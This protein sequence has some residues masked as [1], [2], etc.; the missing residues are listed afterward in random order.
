[1]GSTNLWFSDGLNVLVHDYLRT[2]AFAIVAETIPSYETSEADCY[3]TVLYEKLFLSHDS[4]AAILFSL[5]L[6]LKYLSQQLL[7]GS[8]LLKRQ[9]NWR[10]MKVAILSSHG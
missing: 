2:L 1:M 7:N 4:K 6:F 3:F 9:K 8:K 10:Y 5:F